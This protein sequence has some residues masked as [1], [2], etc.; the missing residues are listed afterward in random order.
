MSSASWRALRM[1]T[2]HSSPY[3][4]AI[5]TN[6][7]RRSSVS[8]GRGMRMMSP[9]ACG[10]RPRSL[11]RSAFSTRLHRRLVPGLD[12]DEARLGYVDVRHLRERRGRAVVVDADAV[13]QARVRAAGAELRELALERVVRL[14]QASS[15]APSGRPGS[16]SVSGAG[17]LACVRDRCLGLF[18]IR[19]VCAAAAWRRAGAGTPNV[20]TR[21]PLGY[22][23]AAAPSQ[24]RSA[25]RA[26]ALAGSAQARAPPAIRL[27]SCPRRPRGS[28]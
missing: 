27:T 22:L 11:S 10:L 9:S 16:S 25:V 7:L 5:F 19:L 20:V 24:R 21:E 17:N 8:G 13:E 18:R 2:L 3:L 6:S 15:P 28:P 26:R 4:R 1:V 14:R 23:G 12:R